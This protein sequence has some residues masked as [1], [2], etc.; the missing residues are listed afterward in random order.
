VAELDT[1]PK[2]TATW[3]LSVKNPNAKEEAELREPKDI[4]AEI[5]ALD[6]ES[7]AILAKIQES[8]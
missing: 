3:D 1:S 8:V 7:E 2:E 6:K 5:I 4:I